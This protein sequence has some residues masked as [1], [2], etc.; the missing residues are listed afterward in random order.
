MINDACSRREFLKKFAMLSCGTLMLGATS[1]GCPGVDVTAL[2][3]VIGVYFYDAAMQ[4]VELRGNNNVPVHTRFE[5]VFSTDMNG[6]SITFVDSNS[7]PIAFTQAWVD[8][9]TLSLTPSADLSLSTDYILTVEYAN[10]SIG[11]PLNPYASASAAF[12]TASI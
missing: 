3:S 9:R 7:N 1:I 10:D 12:K 4:K 5:F 6:A 8:A 2:P 11:N